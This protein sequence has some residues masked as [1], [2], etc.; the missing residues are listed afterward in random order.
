LN[1]YSDMEIEIA[2]FREN[3]KVLGPGNRFVIWTQGCEKLCSNC[4]AASYRESGMG[5]FVRVDYLADKIINNI[6]LNG[7]TISGGEP[8]LQAKQLIELIKL[9][10][11]KRDDL[12]FIIFTGY[13]LEDLVSD[14]AR[15]LIE[16]V[17]LLITGEYKEELNDNL[18]LKG[19]SN[20]KLLF[21]SEKL[22]PW[23]SILKSGIREL[24]IFYK[25]G[26]RFEIVGIPS[27]ELKVDQ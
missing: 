12:N 1:P 8:F 7:I 21:L 17:D 18:G 5:E 16:E 27:R 13:E 14:E 6:S 25:K 11:L 24:Q 19:S 23:E 15:D 26:D 9:I 3:I 22:L 10:R 4:I 2:H 20:Q